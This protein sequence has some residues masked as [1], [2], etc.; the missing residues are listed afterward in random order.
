M[1]DEQRMRPLRKRR[2]ELLFMYTIAV[3][4]YN[5]IRLDY[6][7]LVHNAFWWHYAGKER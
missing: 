3:L 7:S 5:L 4:F 6:D 2:P 1:F